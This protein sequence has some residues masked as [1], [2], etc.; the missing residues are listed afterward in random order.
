[1]NTDGHGEI[2]SLPRALLVP[3]MHLEI[4]SKILER[5]LERLHRA[6][7]KGAEGIAGAEEPALLIEYFDIAGFSLAVLHHLEHLFD[8]W[9]AFPAGLAPAAGL[10]GK[11]HF[12]IMDE[13]DWDQTCVPYIF[14]RQ[15][16]NHWTTREVI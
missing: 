15:I 2:I 12:Y 11:E 16:L 9:Q 4:F 10:P 7:G 6:G 8:P 3:D 5:A 1:M 14:G 13:P